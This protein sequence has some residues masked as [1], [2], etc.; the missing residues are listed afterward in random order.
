[1][2]FRRSARVGALLAM[3]ALLPGLAV[4]PPGAAAADEEIKCANCQKSV[5]KGKPIKV[6]KNGQ[7]YYVC[8]DKCAKE[9]KK[10]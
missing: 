3:L 4:R 1:M 8:S 2:P 9:F 7:V 5:K 6:I 10:K